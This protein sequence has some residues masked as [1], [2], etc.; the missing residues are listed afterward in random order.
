MDKTEINNKIIIKQKEINLE[1]DPNKK[2][3]L[4]RD[5]EILSLRKSIIDTREKINKLI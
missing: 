4:Q 1:R 2:I 3:E 5:L